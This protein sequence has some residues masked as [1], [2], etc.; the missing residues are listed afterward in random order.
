MNIRSRRQDHRA[1][2]SVCGDVDMDSV[3]RFERIL[4]KQVEGDAIL[5]VLDAAQMG[6]IYSNGLAVLVRVSSRLRR[7]GRSFWILNPSQQMRHVLALTNLESLF[8]VVDV[9]E[10]SD[11]PWNAGRPTREAAVAV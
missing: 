5:L 3:E 2:V 4:L 8:P 1:I 11:L 7:Q 10:Y 6:Y 9:P